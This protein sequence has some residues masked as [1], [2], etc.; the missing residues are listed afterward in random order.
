VADAV[1]NPGR[2]AASGLSRLWQPVGRRLLGDEMDA[3]VP[4]L[5][6]GAPGARYTREEALKQL[7]AMLPAL[8]S[9]WARQLL[10]R[11]AAARA[12][13]QTATGAR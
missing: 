11:S 7:E 8:Q 13:T 1:A 5:T 2:A 12:G 6:A 10:G 9:Q 3:M 4:Y